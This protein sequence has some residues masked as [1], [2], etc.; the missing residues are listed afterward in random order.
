MVLV[1]PINKFYAF[2]PASFAL[3]LAVEEVTWRRKILLRDAVC[4]TA[5]SGAYILGVHK[6]DRVSFQYVP[7]LTSES[8]P[9]FSI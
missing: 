6:I 2:L 7:A 5:L 9:S 3:A 4:V 8:A 1:C